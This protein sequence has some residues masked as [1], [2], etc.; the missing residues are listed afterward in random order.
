MQYTLFWKEDTFSKHRH[1]EAFVLHLSTGE[2]EVVLG[3]LQQL[4]L[5]E[6]FKSI[7]S[8]SVKNGFTMEEVRVDSC[9]T[10]VAEN[11]AYSFWRR[12]Y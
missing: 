1:N 8:Y 7:F 9:H 11:F 2:E 4:Y 3:G 6:L 10:V 5:K 12:Y